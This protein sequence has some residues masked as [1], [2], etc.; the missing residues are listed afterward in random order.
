MS[1]RRCLPCFYFVFY[2]LHTSVCI[3]TCWGSAMGSLWAGFWLKNSC[4]PSHNERRQRWEGINRRDNHSLIQTV[5][6]NLYSPHRQKVKPL[7]FKSCLA[8]F[9]RD[10]HALRRM[11]FFYKSSCETEFEFALYFA[12]IYFADSL[13]FDRNISRS[14]TADKCSIMICILVTHK[15]QPGSNAHF[16]NIKLSKPH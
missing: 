5:M 10:K 6:Q 13:P 16:E 11:L 4:C 9:E 8:N 3:L 7:T 15:Q 12:G 1:C 2:Y 14:N